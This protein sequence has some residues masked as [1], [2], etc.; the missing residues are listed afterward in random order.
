MIT[1]L[2]FMR[3][4]GIVLKDTGYSNWGLRYS[5]SGFPEL[6]LLDGGSWQPAEPAPIKSLKE[7][8][9]FRM[10]SLT[11]RQCAPQ[12]REY[13][14]NQ[15][16]NLRCKWPTLPGHSEKGVTWA[17]RFGAPCTATGAGMRPD[18][19]VLCDDPQGISSPPAGLL[20][21]R[22]A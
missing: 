6:I 4:Q 22:N 15:N 2:V 5:L 16:L 9:G 12:S 14:K 8:S 18:K 13:S 17:R 1:I 7:V 3:A 21:A 20:E 10:C 11:T 19:G